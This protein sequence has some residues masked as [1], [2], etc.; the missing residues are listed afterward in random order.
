MTNCIT[1][2]KQYF[3]MDANAGSVT[4]LQWFVTISIETLVSGHKEM[5]FKAPCVYQGLICVLL[6]H[7]EYKTVLFIQYGI[8]IR[9]ILM[10]TDIHAD[11]W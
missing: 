4:V 11:Q 9:W 8:H 5:Y 6:C 2:V 7:T 1:G 3:G 10:Q